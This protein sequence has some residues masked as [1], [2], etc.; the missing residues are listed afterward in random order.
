MRKSYGNKISRTSLQMENFF[1][2]TLAPEMRLRRLV[3]RQRT[4]IDSSINDV[5]VE[6]TRFYQLVG[7]LN[8]RSGVSVKEVTK[9]SG[10]RHY[11]TFDSST[12]GH[13]PWQRTDIT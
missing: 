6:E 7:K 9:K 1:C 3:D 12:I 10:V 13:E 5:I 4:L 8:E 11:R 2:P